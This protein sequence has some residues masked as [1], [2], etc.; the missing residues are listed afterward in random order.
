MLSTSESSPKYKRPI[1]V[2]LNIAAA[3]LLA[4]V[5]GVTALAAKA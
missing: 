3:V 4:S 1:A 2:R 5:M